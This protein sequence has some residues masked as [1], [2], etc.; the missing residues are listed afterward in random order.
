[1]CVI[2]IALLMMLASAG[3]S[4]YEDVRW[5]GRFAY[6]TDTLNFDDETQNYYLYGVTAKF[7]KESMVNHTKIISEGGELERETSVLVISDPEDNFTFIAGNFSANFG[8][9]LAMGKK[10]Y[11]SSDIFSGGFTASR[12]KIYSPSTSGN[13][14]YSFQGAAIDSSIVNNQTV[15]RTAAHYSV[16]RRFAEWSSYETVY[17]TAAYNTLITRGSPA[18]KNSEPVKLTDRGGL[19]EITLH[20][21]F[22]FQTYIFTASI[23]NSSDEEFIW[24]WNTRNSEGSGESRYMAWGLFA[25]YT[26]RYVNLFHESSFSNRNFSDKI[27]DTEIKGR[28]GMTGFRFKHPFFRFEIEYKETCEKFY[29]PFASRDSYPLSRYILAGEIILIPEL[30]LGGYYSSEKRKITSF[31]SY[32][33]PAAVKEQIY[34][35][36][37]F[38]PDNKLKISAART[39][40]SDNRKDSRNRKYTVEYEN[41]AVKKLKALFSAA[42]QQKKQIEDS[43]L[44]KTG[45][46]AGPFRGFFTKADYSWFKVS[47]ANPVF[48]GTGKWDSISSGSYAGESSHAAALLAGRSTDDYRL[49]ASALIHFQGDHIYDKRF[50]FNADIFY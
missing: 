15:F 37:E 12:S 42:V 5:E 20:E 25:E 9:G 23:D 17:S 30:K 44:V 18:E 22:K 43:Y 40:I 16:R 3:S 10:S 32:G 48:S 21:H 19:A 33:L 24:G 47:G 6:K 29:S 14:S 49:S 27:S 1:M 50:Q 13:P 36:T 28:A 38:I 35:D 45:L 11:S 46:R 41:S 39:T 7:S 26:D 2:K 4:E 8:S 31:N 34:A